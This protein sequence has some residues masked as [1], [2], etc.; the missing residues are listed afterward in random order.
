MFALKKL[1]Y[2]VEALTIDVVIGNY[3][4]QNLQNAK[5]FCKE[6][7]IKL[8]VV[9][10]R[11]E[12]GGSLCYLRQVF[13]SKGIKISSCALCGVLR[14]YLINKHAKKLN[15]TK[16]V[17]GH[18]IDDEAQSIMMNFFRNTLERSARLGPISGKGNVKGFVPRVK[19]LFFCSE[20]EIEEYSKK[21]KFPVKYGI[22]P[23]S[24]DVFR[25]HVGN[26]LNDYEKKNPKVKQNIATNFLR[27]LPKLKAKY[28]NQKFKFCMKCGEPSKSDVCRTCQIIGIVRKV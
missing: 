25:R 3:S 15:A 17:T 6:N 18:N 28:K 26:I 9:S 24:V 14:R 4:K 5:K 22:C 13:E 11:K 7:S 2:D 16:I 19:P 21:H 12:F 8:H 27:M 10:F 20:R 23:C 1:G